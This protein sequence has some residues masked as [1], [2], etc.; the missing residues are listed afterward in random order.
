MPENRMTPGRA[1]DT[2]PPAGIISERLFIMDMK[3]E[4]KPV[5]QPPKLEAVDMKFLVSGDVVPGGSP[6]VDPD[7]D[8]DF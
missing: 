4:N 1:E 5:Y 3:K 2:I 7:D 6:V 8:P